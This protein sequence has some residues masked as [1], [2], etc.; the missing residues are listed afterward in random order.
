MIG[1]VLRF[2]SE[3]GFAE[4]ATVATVISIAEAALF[5]FG[6]FQSA[7]WSLISLLS[8]QDLALGTVAILPAVVGFGPMFMN[9]IDDSKRHTV[10]ELRFLY[11]TLLVLSIAVY[12]LLEIFKYNGSVLLSSVL[13]VFGSI[14]FLLLFRTISDTSYL[15]PAFGVFAIVVW[16]LSFGNA[17]FQIDSSKYP[18]IVSSII[19]KD[20]KTISSTVLKAA[21][22]Y[23][24]LYDG[25]QVTAVALSNVSQISIPSKR[26]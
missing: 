3:L 16:P 15:Y 23:I 13:V 11:A 17:F 1:T 8:V 21:S 9:F 24:F 19:L 6:Y 14:C 26:N 7:D 2:K 4:V 22:Q 18:K 12:V 20:G 25:S 5:N 10:K